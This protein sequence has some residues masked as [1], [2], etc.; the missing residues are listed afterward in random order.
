LN[1][2]R[3]AADEIR[4]HAD[5]DANI[6]FGAS[7]NESH[8]EDVLVTLIATGLNGHGR[9]Q[10]M[11]VAEAKRPPKRSG[12]PAKEASAADAYARLI[13]VAGEAGQ[14]SPTIHVDDLEV[15][16]FLRRRSQR[17]GRA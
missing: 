2:V 9:T 5:A 11:P 16:S 10:A 12:R 3:Q 8:G 6:I 13:E 14:A 1:E 7:F 17:A 4:E 15:P